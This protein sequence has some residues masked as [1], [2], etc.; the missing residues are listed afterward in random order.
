MIDYKLIDS[1]NK[2]RLEKF[3]QFTI[4]RPDPEAMWS[5]SLS[6]NDWKNVDAFFNNSWIVKNKNI[7]NNWTIN[8][9]NLKFI[10]KLTPFKH[11]GIFPEQEFEWDLIVDSI[12]SAD[13]K[14]KVLSLFGYT[15]A[16]S[17][18]ALDAGA[19][20]THVDASKPAISWFVENL[21]LNKLE[22]KNVRYIPE[23]SIKFVDREI[24]RGNYYDAVIMDPPVYGHGPHGE[25]WSFSKDFPILLSKV[26]KLLSDNPLFIIVN[27]YAVSTSATTISN[28]IRGIVKSGG[29]IN[30]GELVLNEQ[31]SNKILSTGIYSIWK[32]D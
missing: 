30:N 3:G 10:L 26:S 15:G 14:I 16:S 25:V 24:K 22:N 17:I 5:K 20:V 31:S 32:K 4:D 1:G 9:N 18:V 6:E 7:N 11:T 21:K 12:K 2:R 19:E 28:M 13:R 29:T 8:Y 27:A 23:D